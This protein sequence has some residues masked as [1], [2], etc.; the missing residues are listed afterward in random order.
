M[1]GTEVF[2]WL[3]ATMIALCTAVTLILLLLL[4]T[5]LIERWRDMVKR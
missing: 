3:L 1:P 5:L 4:V 2:G